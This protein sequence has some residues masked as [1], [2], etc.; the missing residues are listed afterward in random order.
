MIELTGE[1][2][3]VITLSIVD[4]VRCLTVKE[5]KIMARH[6]AKI[7]RRRKEEGNP[8]RIDVINLQTN[9]A[10]INPT[11]KPLSAVTE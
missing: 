9:R 7:A 6:L 4:I 3:L 10:D 2:D 1:Q 5:T 8:M 11:K